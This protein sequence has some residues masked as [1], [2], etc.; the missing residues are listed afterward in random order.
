MNRFIKMNEHKMFILRIDLWTTGCKSISYAQ[1]LPIFVFASE[2]LNI[3]ALL[4][5]NWIFCVKILV[6]GGGKY[7]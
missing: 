4:K 5:G 6:Q 1:C 7:N 3:I 2:V